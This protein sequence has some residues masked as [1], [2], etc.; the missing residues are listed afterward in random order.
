MALRRLPLLAFLSGTVCGMGSASQVWGQ[1]LGGA[2]FLSHQLLSQLLRP[3]PADPEGWA[4][5]AQPLLTPAPDPGQ[6]ALLR[7]HP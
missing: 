1:V 4:V 7:F 3:H 2:T 6:E 5:L